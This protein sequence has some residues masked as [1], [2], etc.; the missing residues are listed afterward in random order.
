M[1]QSGRT[2]CGDAGALIMHPESAAAGQCFRGF[3]IFETEARREQKAMRINFGS[4]QME[5]DA[6]LTVYDAAVAADSSVVPYWR[7]T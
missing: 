4:T 3:D 2:L 6:P 1:V 5:F 7:R